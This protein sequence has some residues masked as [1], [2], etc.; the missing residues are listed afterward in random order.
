M[1]TYSKLNSYKSDGTNLATMVWTS[2]KI[3]ACGVVIP[4]NKAS[5][6]RLHELR[7]EAATYQRVDDRVEVR[8]CRFGSMHDTNEMYVYAYVKGEIFVA[9]YNHTNTHQ[10]GEYT[11][12]NMNVDELHLNALVRKYFPEGKPAIFTT[13]VCEEP[14]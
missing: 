9:E 11:L 5:R 12:H 8:K 13:V 1:F 3:V 14:I 4:A 7:V 2:E 6:Q 10:Y